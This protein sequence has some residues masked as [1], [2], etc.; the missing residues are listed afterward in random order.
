MTKLEELLTEDELSE[1]I[2]RSPSSLQKDRVRGVGIP[3]I[4]IGRLVRYLPSVV[5]AELESRTRRSTSDVG[6]CRSDD[7][8]HQRAVKR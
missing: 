2:H 6:M 4:K 3:F 7:P 1:I 8:S 5:E